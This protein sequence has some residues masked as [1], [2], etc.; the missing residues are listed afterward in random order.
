M[1]YHTNSARRYDSFCEGD[2]RD[3]HSPSSLSFS[4]NFGDDPSRGSGERYTSNRMSNGYDEKYSYYRRRS[5][6]PPDSKFP[7]IRLCSV[8]PVTSLTN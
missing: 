8:L 1:A 2:G 6:S 3:L 4:K 5:Q 7:T